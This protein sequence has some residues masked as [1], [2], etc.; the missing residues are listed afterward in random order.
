MTDQPNRT[1][2]VTI[3]GER[4]QAK[5][6]A[7]FIEAVFPE[8]TVENVNP[9]NFFIG[10]EL[11]PLE[12]HDAIEAIADFADMQSK[13]DGLKLDKKALEGALK[14]AGKALS[15]A[16]AQLQAAQHAIHARAARYH[17]LRVA[18]GDLEPQK[19]EQV[20]HADATATWSAVQTV[21]VDFQ[22]KPRSREDRQ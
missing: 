20:W 11:N 4:I 14:N 8:C 19:Y 6:L 15:E 1:I 3:N 18:H 13:F 12:L 22:Y 2:G 7:M 5:A 9:N 21:R 10:G 17:A 16:K